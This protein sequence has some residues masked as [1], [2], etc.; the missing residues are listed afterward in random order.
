MS[1]EGWDVALGDGDKV[2]IGHRLDDPGA[3]SPSQWLWDWQGSLWGSGA[4][5]RLCLQPFTAP[6]AGKEESREAH[7]VLSCRQTRDSHSGGGDSLFFSAPELSWIQSSLRLRKSTPLQGTKCDNEQQTC[8]PRPMV[9]SAPWHNPRP[10][11]GRA[12]AGGL[13]EMFAEHSGVP[14]SACSSRIVLQESKGC[15]GGRNPCPNSF[16]AP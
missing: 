11:P 16:M 12:G 4:G 8:L 15:W 14:G 10:H 1:K 5:S 6:R 9:P 3:L 7:E 13:A 2:S